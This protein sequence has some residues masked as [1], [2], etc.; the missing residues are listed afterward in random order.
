MEKVLSKE[1]RERIDALL[2]KHHPK[3]EK[4]EKETTVISKK[5]KKVTIKT[6]ATSS[7]TR[8]FKEWPIEYAEEASTRKYEVVGT[9]IE[10][11]YEEMDTEEEESEVK[12]LMKEELEIFKQYKEFYMIQGRTKGKMPGFHYIHRVKVKE[13]Y[14]GVPSDVA[15]ML[16][17]PV[18]AEIQ[19]I[20][21]ITEQEIIEIEWKHASVP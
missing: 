13:Q 8:P 5:G 16:S 21:H 2:E 6:E 7:S 1:E 12:K 9:D 11:E 19:D 18:E 17:W 4:K 15:E 10:M 14:P 3:G 20:D